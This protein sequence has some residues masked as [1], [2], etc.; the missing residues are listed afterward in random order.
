MT[1]VEKSRRSLAGFGAAA[2]L[3][4]AAVGLLFTLQAGSDAP[5]PTPQPSAAQMAASRVAQCR[6]DLQAVHDLWVRDPS[7][8]Y[9]PPSCN[10]PGVSGADYMRVFAEVGGG[11]PFWVTS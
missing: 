2:G 8:S 5:K 9:N 6:A 3:I 10:Q 1:R 7:F 4:G 11:R